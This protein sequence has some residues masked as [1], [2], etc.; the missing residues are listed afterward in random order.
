MPPLPPEDRQPVGGR[1]R[2]GIGVAIGAIVG[3][4]VGLLV[5]KLVDDIWRSQGN[6]LTGY[7]Q[8]NSGATI[9]IVIAGMV[10]CALVGREIERRRG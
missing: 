6:V 3:L 4:V 8:L 5:V 1:G 7:R 9:T 2:P 10:I